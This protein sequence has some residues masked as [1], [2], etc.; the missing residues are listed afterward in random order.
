MW[1]ITFCCTRLSKIQQV[2]LVWIT[3]HFNKQLYS[4]KIKI[5]TALCYH[6]SGFLR[7]TYLLVEPLLL[8]LYVYFS[9]RYG[10]KCLKSEVLLNNIFYWRSLQNIFRPFLKTEQ[11]VLNIFRQFD[12]ISVLFAFFA[13]C[14]ASSA[15][16]FVQKGMFH[17]LQTFFLTHVHTRSIYSL[18]SI[19]L[20]QTFHLSQK[21]SCPSSKESNG[22]SHS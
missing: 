8:S 16:S 11:Y 5:I 22:L 18:D 15:F 6:C 10:H 1:Q 9:S 14:S 12:K 2:P 7:S 17:I 20:T 13:P 19:L 21:N 4:L 3:F